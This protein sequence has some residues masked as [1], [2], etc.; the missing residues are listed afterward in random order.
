MER[1]PSAN[2][3]PE[4]EKLTRSH[5]CQAGHLPDQV[6][7]AIIAKVCGQSSQGPAGMRASR[8]AAQVMKAGD[9]G[10]VFGRQPNGLRKEPF[11]ML[12]APAQLIGKSSH[13]DVAR[14]RVNP[15]HRSLDDLL[16]WS[17]TKL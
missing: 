14:S 15:P 13:R 10:I 11:Q 8:T 4:G 2:R 9:A 5:P 16:V 17:S 6:G 1:S 3:A 7:L 12:L